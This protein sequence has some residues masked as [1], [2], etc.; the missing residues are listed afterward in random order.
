MAK[1]AS[2]K[3]L[4]GKGPS[5]NGSRPGGGA[6]L[7]AEAKP[8]ANS[9]TIARNKRATYNYEILERFEAGLAL[10]GTEIKSIREGKAS[11]A[12]AYVRPR[13]GELWLVGA[14]IARY[15]A[16]SRDNHEPLRDRKLLLHRREIRELSDGA[17]Q[18]GLTVVPLHLYL[19]RGMA[20]LKVGLG[21]GKK[22]YDKRQVMA[23]RDADRQ[24]QRGL[25]R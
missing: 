21:R 25:R 24:M 7:S 2:Q 9:K 15:E 22:Q 19:R 16:A 11:I 13:D 5:G 14:T 10:T 18:K 20:K 12:E 6:D 4:R 23:K 8:A 17:D 3:R 1:R